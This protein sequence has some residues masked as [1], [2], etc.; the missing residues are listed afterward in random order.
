MPLMT[1]FLHRRLALLESNVYI[2][3]FYSKEDYFDCVSF[4]TGSESFKQYHRPY[5]TLRNHK[6]FAC[7]IDTA[8]KVSPLNENAT[9]VLI[10]EA[11][12][13]LIVFL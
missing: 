3:V 12:G 4:Q 5:V 7:S 13:I 10:F 1:A 8:L 6:N 2:D 11:L 9:I